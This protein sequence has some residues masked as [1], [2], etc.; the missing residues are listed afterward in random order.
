MLPSVLSGLAF[1]FK[2]ASAISGCV[3]FS[4]SK[5]NNGAFGVK[6]FA[7]T[8]ATLSAPCTRVRFSQSDK[9]PLSCKCPRLSQRMSC[10]TWLFF[11]KFAT[12]A[13][14]CSCE[15]LPNWNR[16]T[17]ERSVSSTR[18][19]R[20]ISSNWLAPIITG[21]SF[22]SVRKACA[23][24]SH[25]VPLPLS[26]AFHALEPIKTSSSAPSFF[27]SFKCGAFLSL[28]FM[29]SPLGFTA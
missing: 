28:V 15:R 13:E 11:A 3:G 14:S 2:N 27:C 5:S 8:S 12:T 1:Q 4:L 7:T 17:A 9:L 10:V 25:S 16:R 24:N 29:I 26:H 6:V 21:F 22:G 20:L 19:K 18:R 23:S